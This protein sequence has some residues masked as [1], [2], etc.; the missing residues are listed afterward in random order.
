[1]KTLVRAFAVATALVASPALA[2]DVIVDVP[3]PP[4]V[5][6]APAFTWTGAYVG[7]QLGFLN[8]D[9][10]ATDAGV[11][12]A[13]ADGFLGGVHAGY[14]FEVAGFV[15]G[16]YADI[17]FTNADIDDG[18]T[19][20]GTDESAGE[21]D[22]IA[23]GMLKV[24]TAFDRA[25]IYAQ[26][27]FAYLQTDL[28]PVGIDEDVDDFGYAVGAGVDFA[29]TDNVIVGADYVF[30]RFDDF[31]DGDDEIGVD[32]VDINAHTFR[33]KLAYKF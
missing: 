24:G 6:V 3:A 21:V 18:F 28:S 31:G 19:F 30:H 27:G 23:R 29:V 25:L 11:G 12:L 20:L 9:L 32:G 14:N 2:A 16:A 15:V 5:D 8:A 17:D 22:L 1:M 13:D 33:A 10:D 4:V 26:G 7:V